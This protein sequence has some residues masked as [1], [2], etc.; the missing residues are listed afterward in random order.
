MSSI[1]V[2]RNSIMGFL[3]LALVTLSSLTTITALPTYNTATTES[4]RPVSPAEQLGTQDDGDYTWLSY[5]EKMAM[6]VFGRIPGVEG[7]HCDPLCPVRGYLI[8]YSCFVFHLASV[9]PTSAARLLVN[10]YDRHSLRTRSQHFV[11]RWFPLPLLLVPI[12]TSST[13]AS[14]RDVRT[15]RINR[16]RSRLIPLPLAIVCNTT[17]N[18]YPITDVEA[19]EAVCSQTNASYQRNVMIFGEHPSNIPF[20]VVGRAC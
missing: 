3:I 10:L 2:N 5:T 15:C 7:E 8:I 20:R 12:S 16:N 4:E 19:G 11:D 13:D 9:R 6:G 1:L 14:A 17:C 18:A